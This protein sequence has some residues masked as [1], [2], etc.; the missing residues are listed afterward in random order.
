MSGKWAKRLAVLLAV[1]LLAALA[2]Y[3]GRRTGYETA[4]PW[5]LTNYGD[6]APDQ[7]LYII[8]GTKERISE[9]QD[10]LERAMEVLAG[11]L[12]RPPPRRIEHRRPK[13]A[14]VFD[15]ILTTQN[16]PAGSFCVLLRPTA[17]DGEA[18]RRLG[19]G[20]GKAPRL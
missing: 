6:Y 5:E 15:Y 7:L 10:H 14:P 20:N 8:E 11:K 12:A 4:R 3:W 1:I 2:F 19:P 17:P 16:R 18:R 9:L 13:W